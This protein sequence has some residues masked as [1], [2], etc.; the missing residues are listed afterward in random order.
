MFRMYSL[1]LLAGSALMLFA[2]CSGGT[3]SDPPM[4]DPPT[5][6]IAS[7]PA[8]S[9]ETLTS[10][11]IQPM[12]TTVAAGSVDAVVGVPITPAAPVQIAL[13]GS[14]TISG[15]PF[16]PLAVVQMRPASSVVLSTPP[17]F[18]FNL[19]KNANTTAPFFVSY[20][21]PGATSWVTLY[22]VAGGVNAEV[23][24]VSFP[25]LGDS[26]VYPAFQLTAGQTYMFALYQ[27]TN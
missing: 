13:T 9:S 1:A 27:S 4:G 6:P 16:T 23:P 18:V 7:P 2:G 10:S 21:A 24:C 8:L 5:A 11:T 12:N 17:G 25:A 26:T 14:A 20:L 19:P 22:S 15:A 3:T